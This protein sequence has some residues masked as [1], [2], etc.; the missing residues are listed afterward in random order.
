MYLTSCSPLNP[1]T[2]NARPTIAPA[3]TSPKP[4]LASSIKAAIAVAVSII[5]L[6]YLVG[7][8]FL[9]R[10]TEQT[11]LKR[12]RKHQPEN[13]QR[14]QPED[15]QR[16]QPEDSQRH[17]PEDSQRHQ[18]EYWQRHQRRLSQTYEKEVEKYSV[19]ELDGRQRSDLS[20]IC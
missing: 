15:S 7:L 20:E 14:H 12:L 6:G 19:W 4:G 5:V 1:N 13:S 16:H 10:A 17:Q 3:P 9:M 2:T 8:I 18:P 11:R